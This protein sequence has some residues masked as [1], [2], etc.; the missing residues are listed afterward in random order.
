MTAEKLTTTIEQI[1]PAKPFE[2]VSS[3]ETA[4]KL[5]D[6]VTMELGIA[7]IQ[8]FKGLSLEVNGFEKV[9]ACRILAKKARC[10][11][12]N[13]QKELTEGAKAFQ[14]NV[15]FAAKRIVGQIEPVESYLEGEEAKHQKLLDEVKKANEAL[16]AAILQD[17]CDRL[18]KVGCPAGNLV[19]LGNMTDELFEW[20]L[21]DQAEK[22]ERERLRVEAE[23]VKAEEERIER[24]RLQRE[25]RERQIKKDAERAAAIAI[26]NQ[27]R[28]AAEKAERE[29]LRQIELSRPKVVQKSEPL[30]PLHALEPNVVAIPAP[31]G[32]DPFPFRPIVEYREP[33]A[34]VSPS[35]TPVSA[36]AADPL[37]PGRN[38]VFFTTGIIDRL[39]HSEQLA[40]ANGKPGI[41]D[42]FRDA[43]NEITS[44]KQAAGKVA[45]AMNH[46]GEDGWERLKAAVAELSAFVD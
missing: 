15:D 44:M 46:Q 21:K 29:R 7:K 3:P 19:A 24:E 20:H 27:K 9:K 31:L 37:P 6:S 5:F 14:K 17:R 22:A 4:M 36:P 16:K 12:V 1:D 30:I 39:K 42:L 13:R 11:V 25:E 2:M 8:E 10:A 28:E 23:R 45:Q 33:P 34:S 41:A 43:V 26:E 18:A 32:A 35:L 40:R 38:E